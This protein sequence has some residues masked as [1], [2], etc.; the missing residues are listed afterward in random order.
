MRL[1]FCDGEGVEWITDRGLM[2]LDHNE[3]CFYLSDG[4]TEKMC[5]Q[6]NSPFSFLSVSVPVCRFTELIGHYLPDPNQIIELLPSRRFTVSEAIRKN[7]YS[8]GQLELLH[9]G[10]EIMQLEGRL[11]ENL[12]LCLQYALCESNKKCQIHRDDLKMIRALG[13][14]IEEEPAT[15]PA[16]AALASEY[17]MSVSKL[18]RCFRQ[19]YGV[20]LHAYVIASRLQKGAELLLNSETSVRE[21]SDIVGYAKPSQFSSAFRKRFGVLPGEYRLSG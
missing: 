18:T 4:S 20:S 14:R 10:F 21:V 13:K 9:T 6:S 11:L 3:A 5:Y 15:I 17:C 16:I 7:L 2:R 1:L 8:I 12:S 19:V